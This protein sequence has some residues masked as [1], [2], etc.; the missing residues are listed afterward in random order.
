MTKFYETQMVADEAQILSDAVT[1]APSV[2]KASGS[3]SVLAGAK[4]ITLLKVGDQPWYVNGKE[5]NA[6]V[7]QLSFGSEERNSVLGAISY[8][9]NGNELYVLEV[10]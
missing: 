5:I 10:R 8:N 1:Y 6:L 4:S 7:N 9:A 3:G 2:T